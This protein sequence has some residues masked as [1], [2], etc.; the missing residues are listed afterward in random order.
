MTEIDTFLINNASFAEGFNEPGVPIAPARKIVVLTC[1]DARI[2][3]STLLGL[4]N[5]DAHIIRNAGGVVT[6]DVIRSLVISQRLLGTREIMLIHHTDCGM[7]T[8]SDDGLRKELLEETGVRP[9]FAMEAFDDLD[10]NLRQ[11][12]ARIETS[13]FVTHKKAIRGFVYDVETGNL[14]EVT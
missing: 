10:V 8:F 13:P 5:G 11:S 3:V 12:I 7:L 4:E 2:D 9:P 6:N 1:M 14:R